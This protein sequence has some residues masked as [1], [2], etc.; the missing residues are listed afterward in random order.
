MSK[1]IET[2]ELTHEEMDLV[3][4]GLAKVLSDVTGLITKADSLKSD[5]TAK[6]ALKLKRKVEEL[7]T[8]ML[9]SNE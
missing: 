6:E 9:Y 8:K 2:I 5:G 1:N 3:T 7:Q 4:M